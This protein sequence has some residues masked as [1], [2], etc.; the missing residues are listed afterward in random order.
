MVQTSPVISTPSDYKA[1]PYTVRVSERSYLYRGRILNLALENGR[2]E[3]VE[4]A[5]AVTILAKRG[6]KLC[7]VRQYRPA[8]GAKT[9]E[10]PAG[11]VE[12]GEE[13]VEA[14]NRE[15]AEEAGLTGNFEHLVSFYT[16]P[17]FCN[18]LSILYLAR[19]LSPASA[20]P[21]DD[22]ELTVEWQTA[23]DMLEKVKLG[24]EVTSGSTMSGLLWYLNHAA[25]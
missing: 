16:S 12:P 5:P 3:V 23:K 25:D 24:L 20:K 9:L 4:H 17:G 10:L 14:A 19:D 18:E 1:S 22:E 13:P 8:V 15:L 2:F 7:F 6:G 11:L 21:D